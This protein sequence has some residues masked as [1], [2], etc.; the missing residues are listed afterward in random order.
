MADTTNKAYTSSSSANWLHDYSLLIG[1]ATTTSNSGKFTSYVDLDSKL[2]SGNTSGSR[3]I[4]GL[5]MKAS[6]K[7]DNNKDPNKSEI[8]I[9]NL[10]D[11]TVNYI[12]KNIRNNVAV[13][14]AVGYEG[15]T[16]NLVFKGTV[17]W[18]SDTFDGTDR[19][20][21]LHCVDGGINLSLARSSKSYPK[22]TKVSTII[23]D[24]VGDLGT[25]VGNVKVDT[26][27]TISSASVMCGSTSHYLES[28]CRGND[29]NFSI[30]DGSVFITP[31][32][33]MFSAR[34]SYISP[35]TGLLGSPQPFHNDIKPTKKTTKSSKKAK[36][37]TD[38]VKFRCE[39]DG[40][41]VPEKTVWLKSRDYDGGFK[42]VTVTHTLDYEGN[43]W[44][45]EV[46]AVSVSAYIK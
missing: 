24:L 35:D 42:V 28:I 32:S 7:K 1:T 22:G 19:N 20:T 41:L 37:P 4:K 21:T 46:E 15:Q 5:Q 17:Q 36:K 39:V 26:D 12:N 45:T 34:T 13:A 33:Q 11:D 14:L 2:S 9:V 29:H 31:R 40:S 3:L 44:Y 43:E 30:Q 25:P 10:S 18:V 27:K 8:T 16:L 38:G 6:I 23:N